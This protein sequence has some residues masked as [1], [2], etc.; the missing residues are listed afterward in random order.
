MWGV[1]F[2]I[3][4][5]LDR[6]ILARYVSLEEMGVYGIG[7]MFGNIA[8]MIVS[9]NMSAYLPRVKK[10]DSGDIDEVKRLTTHYSQEIQD[11]MLIVI[12]S[13]AL[14]SELTIWLFAA[15]YSGTLA[16]FVMI[17]LL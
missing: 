3:F 9:A 12:F 17:V 5:N 10:L 15:N 7:F 2:I 4:Q 1:Y 8:G 6:V 13:I 14:L 11:L 16:S